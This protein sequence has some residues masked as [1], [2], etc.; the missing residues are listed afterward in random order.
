MKNGVNLGNGVVLQLLWVF[1][2]LLLDACQKVIIVAKFMRIII[3]IIII[4]I[5]VSRSIKVQTAIAAP[6]SQSG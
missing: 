6:T 3:I 2:A 4:H 1:F 5:F